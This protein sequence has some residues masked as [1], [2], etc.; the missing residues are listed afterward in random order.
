MLE[1]LGHT[2]VVYKVNGF[3]F[4]QALVSRLE[5]NIEKLICVSLNE[6]ANLINHIISGPF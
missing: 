2:L 5:R 1:V 4:P 3:S 6:L